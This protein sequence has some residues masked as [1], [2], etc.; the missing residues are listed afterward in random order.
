MGGLE[1][2]DPMSPYGPQAKSGDVRL[3]AAFDPLRTSATVLSCSR[4]CQ[5]E[6][7]GKPGDEA[8][9]KTRFPCHNQVKVRDLVFTRYAQ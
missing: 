5:L 3:C 6:E 1:T 8:F 2:Y 9:M 4:L 7:D